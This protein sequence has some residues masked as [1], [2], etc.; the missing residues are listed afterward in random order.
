MG[1]SEPIG[2]TS[3]FLL[4]VQ[5]GMRLAL[6]GIVIGIG[7]AFWPHTINCEEDFLYGFKTWDPLA[8]C[9]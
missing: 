1:P 2:P 9:H 3:G 7:A 4:S 6:A 5:H 8:L